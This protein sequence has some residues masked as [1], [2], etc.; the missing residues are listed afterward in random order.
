MVLFCHGQASQ[1]C[2]VAKGHKEDILCVAWTQHS[3]EKKLFVTGSMDLCAKVWRL[4]D[5]ETGADSEEN[6]RLETVTTYVYHPAPV[7]AIAT[8]PSNPRK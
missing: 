5:K 3:D 2:T 4:V 1:L 7:L 8:N 6:E